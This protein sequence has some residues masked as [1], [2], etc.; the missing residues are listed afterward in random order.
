MTDRTPDPAWCSLVPGEALNCISCDKPLQNMMGKDVTNQ[1][2]YG[3]AFFTHGHWPSSLFDSM[4][5]DHLEISVC[6]E[7]LITKASRQVALVQRQERPVAAGPRI[8]DDY[9]F[10][11]LA[12]HTLPDS[13]LEE[14]FKSFFGDSDD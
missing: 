4:S 8:L 14:E 11:N 3:L 7:C 10:E 12:Y 5:A 1:P 13:A 6:D 9:D 2:V